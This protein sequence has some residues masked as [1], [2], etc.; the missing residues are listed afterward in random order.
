MYWDRFEFHHLY[1]TYAKLQSPL[2]AQR[3]PDHVD[4]SSSQTERKADGMEQWA[5]W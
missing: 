1:N 5:G 3:A 4:Q 2:P